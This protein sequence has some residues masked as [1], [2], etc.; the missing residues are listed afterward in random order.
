MTTVCLATEDQLSEAVAEKLLISSGRG[1]QIDLRLGRKGSGY[2][3]KKLPDFNNIA[4]NISPVL[5][6]V[7]L[8]DKACAPALISQWSSEKAL[9]KNLLFR[10]AVRETEAWLLADSQAF[11]DFLGISQARIP[12]EPETLADPKQTLLSLVKRSRH[13]RIR[14]EILPE[15]GS[16]AQVGFGYNTILSQFVKDF[17]NP[18]RAASTA[19]SLASAIAR[20]ENL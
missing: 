14:S 1:F 10:V 16:T 3:R 15:P 6:L 11:A 17:W 7:D 13:R 12:P 20:I 8:D 2:L 19:P 18:P 4:Q 5:L 9:T